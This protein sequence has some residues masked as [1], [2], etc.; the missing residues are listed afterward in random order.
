MLTEAGVY[1]QTAV[2]FP[3]IKNL[4]LKMVPK[5]FMDIHAEH[6]AFT[7]KKVSKRIELGKTRNDLIEGLL[8]KQDELVRSQTTS[9]LHD[10]E[11]NRPR[12]ISTQSD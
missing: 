5:K 3:A 6:T 8:I 7:H 9:T 11:S 1:M 10:Y 12:E 2:H 4:L